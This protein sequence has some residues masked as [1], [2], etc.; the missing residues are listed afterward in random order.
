VYFFIS[1]CSLLT[2]IGS[3][4]VIVEVIKADRKW[5]EAARL[6]REAAKIREEHI[7]FLESELARKR[8]ARAARLRDEFGTA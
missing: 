3:I 6:Y 1:V 4:V 8:A 2:I 5:S 7:A